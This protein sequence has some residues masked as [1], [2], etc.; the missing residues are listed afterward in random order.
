MQEEKE[1]DLNLTY[2]DRK[3]D[4]SKLKNLP[5]GL[6]LESYFLNQ[7]SLEKRKLLKIS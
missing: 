4:C 7:M 2:S 5:Q 1:K 3:T 6:L